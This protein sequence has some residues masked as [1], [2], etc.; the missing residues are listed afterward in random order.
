MAENYRINRTVQLEGTYSDCIVLQSLKKTPNLEYIIQGGLNTNIPSI[1]NS[2][3]VVQVVA[4][5]SMLLIN[6]RF[7]KHFTE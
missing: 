3:C 1:Q 6:S 5:D 2:L 4:K 7:E